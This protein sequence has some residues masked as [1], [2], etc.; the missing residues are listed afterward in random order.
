[1]EEESFKSLLQQVKTKDV[2]HYQEILQKLTEIINYLINHRFERLVQLLYTV[3]I[4]E[5][6]LKQTLRD[7]SDKE[8]AVVIAELVLQRQI[9]KLITRQNQ[10]NDPADIPDDERW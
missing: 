2:E 10:A 1:V 5:R 8:A 7:N 4:D 6:Q 3:D 9:Q